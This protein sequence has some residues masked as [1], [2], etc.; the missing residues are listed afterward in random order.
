MI[1]GCDDVGTGALAYHVMIGAVRA[2]PSW[3]IPGLNDSKALSSQR[4]EE[5][6]DLLGKEVQ[7]G[8]IIVTLAFS[9]AQQIDEHGLASCLRSCYISAIK[10][11]SCPEDSIII[12]GHWRYPEDARIT[13]VIRADSKYPTV[14]AASILAKVTRDRQITAIAKDYPNYELQVHKGYA[15][16]LHRGLIKKFGLSDIHRKSFKIRE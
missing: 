9:S 5:V 11:I 10:K 14:M 16:D 13:S 8:N 3:T 7:A 15:T 12:D 4:R 6:F 2:E 1:I